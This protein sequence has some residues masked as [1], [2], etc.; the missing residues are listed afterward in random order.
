MHSSPPA[1]C[2]HVEW[3]LG[4][5]LDAPVDLD[6]SVQPASPAA[7]RAD[8]AWVGP[9][10][11][12]GRIAAALQKWQMLR[13]EVTEDPSPG[14]DGERIMFVPGRGVYRAATS[15]N[16]DLMIAEDRIRAL[17]ATCRDPDSLRHGLNR[18]LGTEWDAEL[19]PY[20]HYGED[21]GQNWL[22][23]VS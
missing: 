23:Q 1:V 19:E 9:P 21:A 4:R 22:S 10:G 12:G 7:W 11:T 5:V 8:C 16:G 3:A 18:L 13:F 14:V 2:P 17:L 20:R 15:A 6:W